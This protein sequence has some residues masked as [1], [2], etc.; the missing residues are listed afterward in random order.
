[1]RA[2]P[3]YERLREFIITQHPL[4]HTAEDFWRMVW[5]H[6]VQTVVVLTP[7][8]DEVRIGRAAISRDT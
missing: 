2:S 8:D 4:A 7:A 5:D 6:N 1:M 3:G